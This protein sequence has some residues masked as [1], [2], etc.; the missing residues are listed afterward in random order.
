MIES[1]IASEPPDNTGGFV[2]PRMIATTAGGNTAAWSS[3]L[4]SRE[5]CEEEI[6]QI[7]SATAD[8]GRLG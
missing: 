1:G 5:R 7:E 6:Q 3:R 8:A 2:I 4:R